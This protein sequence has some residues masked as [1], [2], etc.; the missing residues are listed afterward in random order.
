MAGTRAGAPVRR[1]PPLHRNGMTAGRCQNAYPPTHR[2]PS[3][4]ASVLPAVAG[5]SPHGGH[6]SSMKPTPGPTRN[7]APS[8]SRN[9]P[10]APSAR[11]GSRCLP[12][13]RSSPKSTPHP[14]KTNSH[15]CRAPSL[16]PCPKGARPSHS[17]PRHSIRRRAKETR[18]KNRS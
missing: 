12:S 11:S 5:P 9:H 16:R 3:R 6:F 10:P 15:L 4:D 14:C 8:T 18:R 13:L 17:L 2:S 1:N 7:P